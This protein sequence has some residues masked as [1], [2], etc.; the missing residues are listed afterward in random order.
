MGI[1]ADYTVTKLPD[2]YV[3]KHTEVF[4]GYDEKWQPDPE[5]P[6]LKRPRVR[7]E[8]EVED[9]GGYLFTFMRGHSIRLTSLEQIKQFGLDVKPRL[10]DDTTGLEVNENGVPVDIANFINQS[11]G[12]MMD[13]NAGAEVG[14]L[15]DGIAPKSNSGDPIADAIDDTE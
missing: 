12:S 13:G 7:T 4:Y 14:G 6:D 11:S 10:I 3:T 5:K 9:R 1:R 15:M 8:R 2:T